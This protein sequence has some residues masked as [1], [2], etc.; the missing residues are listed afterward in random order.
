[1]TTCG[2]RGNLD[3]V[4]NHA[5][6]AHPYTQVEGRMKNRRLD[7]A[8]YIEDRDEGHYTKPKGG[9]AITNEKGEYIFEC[10]EEI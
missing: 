7:G 5:A 9:K 10:L 2:F 4:W 8:E 6:E 3:E 1:M